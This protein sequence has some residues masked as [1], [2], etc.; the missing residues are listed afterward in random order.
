MAAADRDK[1]GGGILSQEVNIPTL[2]S[3]EEEV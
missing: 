2:P 3:I 1:A